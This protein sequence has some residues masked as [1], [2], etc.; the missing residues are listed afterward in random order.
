MT[1]PYKNETIEQLIERKP[2]NLNILV[3]RREWAPSADSATDYFN[4]VCVRYSYTPIEIEGKLCSIGV[5][6]PF[7]VPNPV[8]IAEA[9]ASLRAVWGDLT[10]Q[11]NEGV[12]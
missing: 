8:A 12:L 10:V 2:G 7:G 4:R 6:A 1:D 9:V 11:D 5:A 3:A